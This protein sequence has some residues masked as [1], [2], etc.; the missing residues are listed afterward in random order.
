M[1]GFQILFFAVPVVFVFAVDVVDVRLFTLPVSNLS[2][3]NTLQLKN[4]KNLLESIGQLDLGTN[5]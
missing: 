2:K 1:G 3:S 4:V 5:L